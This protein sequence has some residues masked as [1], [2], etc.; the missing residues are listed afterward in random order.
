VTC[1]TSG[2]KQ[3]YGIKARIRF[4]SPG[5]IMLALRRFRFLLVD[6]EVRIWLV[7]AL[8]RRILPVPVLRNLFAAP[9][10]DFIFGMVYSVFYLYYL[11]FHSG[12]FLFTLGNGRHHSWNLFFAFRNGRRFNYRLR[13]NRSPFFGF[14]VFRCQNHD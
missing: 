6:F 7:K 10:F 3:G 2:S 13:F 14:R 12:N 9:E 4:A 8:F 5:A 11:R 1:F